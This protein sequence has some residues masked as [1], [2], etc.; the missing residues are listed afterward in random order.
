MDECG[1]LIIPVRYMGLRF[2]AFYMRQKPLWTMYQEIFATYGLFG[3]DRFRM[4]CG[5]VVIVDSSQS[6]MFI[7]KYGQDCA[8]TESA[9]ILELSTKWS[10]HVSVVYDA[11]DRMKKG[12][13]L[14]K[15]HKIAIALWP[16]DS[17]KQDIGIKVGSRHPGRPFVSYFVKEKISAR[18]YKAWIASHAKTAVKALLDGSVDETGSRAISTLEQSVAKIIEEIERIPLDTKMHFNFDIPDMDVVIKDLSDATKRAFNI[19][20]AKK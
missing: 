11:I 9:I 1:H 10:I 20:M 14:F 15:R 13:P 6:C 5:Q 18:N 3:C 12:L 2:D 17:L 7:C 4:K 19:R 16:D 8:A